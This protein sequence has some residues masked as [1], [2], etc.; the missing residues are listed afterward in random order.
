MGISWLSRLFL[1]DWLDRSSSVSRSTSSKIYFKVNISLSAFAIIPQSSFQSLLVLYER[2]ERELA[3]MPRDYA[4]RRHTQTVIDDRVNAVNSV[5]QVVSVAS[6]KNEMWWCIIFFSRKM[7]LGNW[8]R[9]L[10]VDKWRNWLFRYLIRTPFLIFLMTRSSYSKSNVDI[11]REK[12][13][14]NA[15]GI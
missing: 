5:T 2:I 4:Y 3:K 13:N 7:I 11:F 14:W 6:K 10:T 1:D 15:P 12:M 9:K 8:N